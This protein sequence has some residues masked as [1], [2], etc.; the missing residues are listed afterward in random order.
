MSDMYQLRKDVDRLLEDVYGINS[1]I[2]TFSN[3]PKADVLRGVFVERSIDTGEPSD[4]G[5]LDA[6]LEFY[7]V[8]SASTD[9]LTIT[10]L[11]EEITSLKTRITN[12]ED[13]LAGLPPR[14][15]VDPEDGEIT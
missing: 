13:E 7:G 5:T 15:G 12:L 2:V 3:T 10:L 6:I 4:M 1:K 9:N 11:Q 14:V 8:T